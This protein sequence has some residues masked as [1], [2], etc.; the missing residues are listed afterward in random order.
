MRTDDKSYY[1]PLT[2]R[3]YALCV[4]LLLGILC[5]IGIEMRDIERQLAEAQEYIDEYDRQKA[6]EAKRAE[7]PN[8]TEYDFSDWPNYIEPAEWMDGQRQSEDDYIRYP[9]ILENVLITHY[10]TCELC[11]GRFAD[12]YTYDGSVATPGVTIAADLSILP[13]GTIVDIGGNLYTVQDT[14]V[15]GYHI[16]VLCA[17][18]QEALERGKYYTDI[19]VYENSTYSTDGME[20]MFDG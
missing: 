4:F 14:G 2:I 19:L 20:V 9:Y 5:Y 10:C 13:I 8:V 3:L 17:S 18:H 7:T 11:C 12:G 15:R 6:E 16:D 1:S